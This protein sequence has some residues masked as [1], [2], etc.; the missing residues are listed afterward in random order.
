MSVPT[1]KVISA[2]ASPAGAAER[3][4]SVGSDDRRGRRRAGDAHDKREVALEPVVA[5]EH[6]GSQ[7]PGRRRDGNVP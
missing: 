3:Q 4:S 6:D 2:A 5:P 7:D 1:A